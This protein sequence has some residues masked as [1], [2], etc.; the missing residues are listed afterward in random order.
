MRF[1]IAYNDDASD[2][3][4]VFF[5]FCGEEMIFDTGDCGYESIVFTPP[6]L[7][8]SILLQNITECQV[9][10]IANHGDTKSIDG[11]SGDIVSV[12]TNN[13]LF[14]GK[15]LYV[16]SCSCAKELKD[17]LVSDGLLSFWGYDNELKVWNG[18]P[19]YGRC[20]M[21]GMKNLLDGKNIKEAKEAMLV[22]FDN[23]I[24]EL[25][26]QYPDNPILAADL[27][28]DREA[29]VVYGEDELKLS[30]LT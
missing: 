9:C 1:L 6:F 27:L 29:L 21:S 24:I 17:K 10:F 23:D 18:Y 20:C 26:E 12:N 19:Q 2:D 13:K 28:D 30:D 8:N 4:C 25:E 5:K 14:A 11:C 3:A 16:V 15:L 7:T 22:Q